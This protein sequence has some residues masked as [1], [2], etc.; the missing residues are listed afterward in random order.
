MHEIEILW[1]A[2]SRAVASLRY[3]VS[4]AD[5]DTAAVLAETTRVLFAQSA[6]AHDDERWQTLRAKR[7]ALLAELDRLPGQVTNDPREIGE[8]F[9]RVFVADARKRL[10]LAVDL[11][12][13][14][15]ND[16]EAYPN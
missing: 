8:H 14:C 10:A 1:S 15:P 7:N 11:R 16:H 5:L 2:T 4:R 3:H 6:D 13:G 12:Q 9:A